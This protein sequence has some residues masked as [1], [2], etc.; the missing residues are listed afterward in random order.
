M[1]PWMR[2]LLVAAALGLAAGAAAAKPAAPPQQP[3]A[4]PPAQA[5]AAAPAPVKATAEQRAEAERLEP[6]ARAAFWAREVDADPKDME[7]RIKLARSLRALGRNAEA[8]DVADQLL[9][10]QPDNLDALLESAKARLAENQG[11]YAIDPA[12]HAA[13]LAPKDWRPMAVLG[14]A[15]EQSQ[16]DDEALRAH[17]KALK[18][19][20]NNPATLTNL[21]LYYAT[22]GDPAQA[23]TYLRKA[24]AAPGAGI[25]ERQNLALVLG[26]QGRV[27]E[28][29][30]L[31][32]QDLPPAM[33]DNNLAYM[34][35]ESEPVQQR[36]WRSLEAT[37]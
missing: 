7:A 23:E 11:F 21:G 24:V 1:G 35:G 28:A 4:T 3:A 22:H 5:P 20:P 29:E 9:V 19:A 33:V 15:L 8:A 10:M 31:Q 36:T 16:R 25:Q 30:Q 32:R 27:A 34:R 14:V 12:E 2:S 13:A 26:L 6:V 18:L 17:L 37:Q